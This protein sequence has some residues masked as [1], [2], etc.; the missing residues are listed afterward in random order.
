[1]E[2]DKLK[3]SKYSSDEDKFWRTKLLDNKVYYIT[4]V[5]QIVTPKLGKYITSK[6][7]DQSLYKYRK[8]ISTKIDQEKHKNSE[9]DL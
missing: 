2:I 3:S 6:I 4:I 9:T 7:T 8:K 5:I 1:M